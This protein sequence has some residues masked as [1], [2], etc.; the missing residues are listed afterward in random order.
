MTLENH[1]LS[2]IHFNSVSVKVSSNYQNSSHCCK[3]AGNHNKIGKA[4]DT[5]DDLNLE[6][7]TFNAVVPLQ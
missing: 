7:S 6:L 4:P 5:A 3:M 1:R 2:A